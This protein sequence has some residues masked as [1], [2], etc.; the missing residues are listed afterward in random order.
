MRIIHL[1]IGQADAAVTTRQALHKAQMVRLPDSDYFTLLRT[2]MGWSGDL[3][4]NRV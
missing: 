2:K 1:G 4:G 3:R